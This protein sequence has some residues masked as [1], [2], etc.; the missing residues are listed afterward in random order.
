M[1][2]L[3]LLSAFIALLTDSDAQ[4][5]TYL[6]FE[7]GPQ[8]SLIKVADPGN[9]FQ[10]ANVKSTMAGFTL[11][12]EIIPN[13]S[14]VT[15]AYYTP[16]RS[17]IN[18]IDDRPHQ[19][20]WS[21]YTSIMIPVRVEYRIQPTEYPFSFTPRLGYVYGQVSQP[22]SPYQ[23]S[24]VLSAPDG[25]AY[26]YDLAESYSSQNLHMLEIG[27]GLNLRLH[28]FWQASFNISYMTGFTEPMSASLDYSTRGNAETSATYTTSGN[29]IQTTLAFNV[30]VSNIWQNRNYR[31]RARVEK[32]VYK[33]KPTSKKGQVYVGAEI[34]SLW[35]QFNASNP[36]IGARPME[37]RGMFRYA[38]MHTGAYI[39]YM[40]TDE[41][42]ID[43]GALYQQSSMFYAIMYDHEVDFVVKVPAPLYLGYRCA[44]GTSMMFIR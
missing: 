38:N 21:S 3:I 14:I 11:G 1:R 2:K 33:G 36:A 35:R 16:N 20:R 29:S 34:G 31:I 26:N 25:T 39:G 44:S 17:G 8:W 23:A 6:T 24:G 30:P 41:V 10:R 28:G 37:G 15:G 42:G 40:V 7:S 4:L 9:V 43:V 19:S 22:G 18:M 13:L 27:V 32:S 12:Q 5:K